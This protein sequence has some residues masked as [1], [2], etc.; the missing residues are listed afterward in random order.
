MG[1][2]FSFQQL[3]CALL[4]P[5]YAGRVYITADPLVIG[6]QQRKK[7]LQV[8]CYHQA[9]RCCA[10]I[11]GRQITTQRDMTS[12]QRDQGSAVPKFFF[13]SA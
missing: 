10:V 4:R 13:S 9:A 7:A 6:H 8:E 12:M 11:A 1:F 5:L 3:L 2:F